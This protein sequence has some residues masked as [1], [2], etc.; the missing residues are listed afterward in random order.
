MN[1]SMESMQSAVSGKG[2]GIRKIGRAPNRLV[3]S[4]L[5]AA[6]ALVTSVTPALGATYS[7]SFASSTPTGFGKYEDGLVATGGG[8]TNSAW[9]KAAGSA[10]CVLACQK[11][12]SAANGLKSTSVTYTG[13]T[14]GSITIAINGTITA[15]YSCSANGAATTSSAQAD[16]QIFLYDTTLGKTV[17]QAPLFA[18]QRMQ[19]CQTT[20]TNQAVT[21]PATTFSLPSSGTAKFTGSYIVNNHKYAAFV[22]VQAT[23][24]VQTLVLGNGTVSLLVNES[25]LSGSLTW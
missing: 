14:S 13:I 6:L 16:A 11:G 5:I 17:A 25:N 12:A 23:S 10:N 3:A 1:K 2:A 4:G 21:I 24:G 22:R 15:T 19:V 9:A 18:T 20:V 7:I 8:A